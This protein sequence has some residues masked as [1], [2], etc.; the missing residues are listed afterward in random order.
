MVGAEVREVERKYDVD[1]S[2]PIP[3]LASLPGVAQVAE[4]VEHELVAEYV[5]TED[6]VLAANRVTMRRRTG[7]DDDGW[8]LKLPGTGDERDELRRPAGT[9]VRRVPLPLTRLVRVH[10]RGQALLPVATLRTRRA[11]HRLLDAEGRVLAEVCDDRVSARVGE[12]TP[13]RT[14]REWEVELVTGD[15]ALLDAAGHAL[16]DAG[17]QPA[18]GPSKLARALGDRVPRKARRELPDKPTAGDV[19]MAYVAEQVEEIKRRDPEVRRNV[20]DGVHKMRVA[21]RRLRSALATYRPVLDRSV[22]DPIRDEV[23][24]VAGE[25]GPARD[26]EVLREHL[27]AEID[28]EPPELLLGRVRQNVDIQLRRDQRDALKRAVAALDDPLYLH[29][30]DT[31][32]QLVAAPPLINDVPAERLVGRLLRHDWKRLS[33]RVDAAFAAPKVERDPLLHEARKAAKRIRYAAE[34]AS[35]VLGERADKLVDRAKKIQNHLGAH[36]DAVVFRPAIRQLAVQAHLSGGN[37]FS[38]GRLHALEQWRA[39]RAEET[40]A[41]RWAKVSAR[42]PQSWMR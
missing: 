5:D 14:W 18:T 37:G 12:G 1:W 30:L 17:A 24:R 36:Q 3:D 11:V 19:L 28:A 34:S 22:T 27:L 35:P 21:M 31:L 10:T 16:L 4:P 13:E 8:H 42:Y 25:L 26:L 23:R 6:L 33:K 32:D 41:E 15:E 29:L 9:S 20:D 39:D 40:F 2:T 38:Y 7:G